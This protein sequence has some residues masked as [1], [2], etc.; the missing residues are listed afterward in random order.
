MKIFTPC[1]L[2]IY[3]VPTT[4]PLP[5][6]VSEATCQETESSTQD[7]EN[8]GQAEDLRQLFLYKVAEFV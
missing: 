2:F 5:P 8:Q 7:S 3:A 1:L 4:V 6:S